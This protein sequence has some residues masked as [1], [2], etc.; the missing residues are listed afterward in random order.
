[1]VRGKRNGLTSTECSV[2]MCRF[3]T[4]SSP[5]WK[6]SYHNA[7]QSEC[8]HRL[9]CLSQKNQSERIDASSKLKMYCCCRKMLLLFRQYFPAVG[10]AEQDCRYIFNNVAV[11]KSRTFSISFFSAVGSSFHRNKIVATFFSNVACPQYL[12][13]GLNKRHKLLLLLAWNNIM[14]NLQTII[15]L[16][17]IFTRTSTHSPPALLR[18]V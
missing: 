16:S 7:T 18:A 6:L 10:S 1:M 2:K 3:L 12:L 5:Y 8:A 13:E 11:A 4:L 14:T 15:S 17:S 9:R